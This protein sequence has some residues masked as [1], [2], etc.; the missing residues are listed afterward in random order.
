MEN[1]KHFQYKTR[2]HHHGAE[3]NAQKPEPMWLGVQRH[4]DEAAG[5]DHQAQHH[6]LVISLAKRKFA[7]AQ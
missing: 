6:Q 4:D 7:H 2:Q 5:D 1:G 3:G